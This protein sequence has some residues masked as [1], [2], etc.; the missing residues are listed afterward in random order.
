MRTLA[1]A[2]KVAIVAVV[3]VG[4]LFA[5]NAPYSVCAV[6]PGIIPQFGNAR[7]ETVNPAAL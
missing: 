3:V 5:Y 6:Q 1:D 4:A 2:A 7:G